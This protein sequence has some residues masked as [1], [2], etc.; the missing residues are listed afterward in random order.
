MLQ[1]KHCL[2]F[3]IQL[4]KFIM[5]LFHSATFLFTWV[6]WSQPGYNPELQY[7]NGQPFPARPEHYNVY[8]NADFDRLQEFLNID[9]RIADV[10]D[11]K[12]AFAVSKQPHSLLKHSLIY[13]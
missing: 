9:R 6:I 8:Y 2:L 4:Q 7:S 3:N 11:G 1:T 5:D 13:F 12:Q 10:V